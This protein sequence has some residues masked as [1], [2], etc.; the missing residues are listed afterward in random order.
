MQKDNT[1]KM[2]SMKISKL[3]ITMGILHIPQKQSTRSA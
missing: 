2:A 1:D 3:M